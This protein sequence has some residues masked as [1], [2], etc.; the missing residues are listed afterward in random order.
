[1]R[2]LNAIKLELDELK[3][4]LGPKKHDDGY[5]NL[6]RLEYLMVSLEN[7]RSQIDKL[8]EGLTDEE[9]A[10]VAIEE[11]S[12]CKAYINAM[13]NGNVENAIKIVDSLPDY[14]RDKIIESHYSNLKLITYMSQDKIDDEFKSYFNET[15]EYMDVQKVKEHFNII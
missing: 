4:E 10:R 12:E 14:V 9:K 3:K 11:W 15:K 2:N 1:M 6:K 5:L 8:L 13:D 7:D